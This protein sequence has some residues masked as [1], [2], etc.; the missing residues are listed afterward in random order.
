MVRDNHELYHAFSRKGVWQI[1][2]LVG[3]TPNC[4]F[5]VLKEPAEQWVTVGF[6][7]SVKARWRSHKV[8]QKRQASF[9]KATVG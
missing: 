8:P 2:G 4:R 3:G 6:L 9:G 1:R 7:G 5:V